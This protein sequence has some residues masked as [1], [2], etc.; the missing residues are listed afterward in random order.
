MPKL[1]AVKAKI[2]EAPYTDIPGRLRLLADTWNP[3][4]GAVLVACIPK[5]ETKVGRL[6]C[7]YGE[8]LTRAEIIGE[9]EIAKRQYLSE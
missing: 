4:H 1:E 7:E 2:A 5:D 9:F 6:F 3:E 8:L